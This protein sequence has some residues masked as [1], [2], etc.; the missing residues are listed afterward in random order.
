VERI[1]GQIEFLNPSVI[2]DVS[3]VSPSLRLPM[4][5]YAEWSAILQNIFVNAYNA[6]K[7][8][9]N[10]RLDVS[11][12][13]NATHSWLT[14]QDTG[15]GIDLSRSERLFEPFVRELEV[16]DSRGS[17]A[18]G[19]GGLGLTIVRMIADEIGC[20]VQ[21]VYPDSDHSTAVQVSWKD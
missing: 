20:E 11:G 16:D 9:G 19:G 12:G 18:L 8:S 10:R 21:F 3:D 2:T 15:V 5:T 4:A 7:R 14:I 1:L 17:L 13:S 6:M